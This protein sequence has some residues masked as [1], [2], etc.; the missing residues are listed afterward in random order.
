MFLRVFEICNLWLCM[1]IKSTKYLSIVSIVS[2]IFKI[3]IFNFKNLII[4]LHGLLRINLDDN[5][6]K[7][8]EQVDFLRL[9][10]LQLLSVRNNAISQMDPH[11]LQGLIYLQKVDF[12]GN[13]LQ[14]PY[15][16]NFQGLNYL[17][18]IY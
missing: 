13:I 8:I 1:Q 11:V 4:D 17:S 16:L 3:I 15:P 18:S 6:L 12:S 5:R 2:F 10:R 7:S 14:A 9:Q